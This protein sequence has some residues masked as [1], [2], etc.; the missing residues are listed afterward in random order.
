MECYH[1]GMKAHAKR[2]DYTVRGVPAE[3]DRLLRQRSAKLKRSLNQV[4]LDE[5]TRAT[6]GRP[7]KSDFSDLVGRWSRDPAFDKVVASQRQVD[8]AKW[9]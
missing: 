1:A 6:T 2:V 9:K 4:I 3:V 8:W 7:Q 5:L